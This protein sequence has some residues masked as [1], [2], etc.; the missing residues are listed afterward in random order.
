[1]NIYN[2]KPELS[3]NELIA[4]GIRIEMDSSNEKM[5][6]M[7]SDKNLIKFKCD[8]IEEDYPQEF[9]ETNSILELNLKKPLKSMD[10]PFG[11]FKTVQSEDLIF[12]YFEHEILPSI[13]A[14]LVEVVY[15]HL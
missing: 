15:F 9:P 11:H 7:I 8:L 12:G 10:L 5:R 6:L 4:H 2:L 13:G 3:V 1:M 14:E